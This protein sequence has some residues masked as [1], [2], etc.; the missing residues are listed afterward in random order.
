M[1][2]VYTYATFDTPEH[3]RDAIR[4]LDDEFQTRKIDVL[5]EDPSKPWP[6]REIPMRLTTRMGPGLA[7]G[8]VFGAII[9]TI[10]AVTT[11]LAE[12]GP[13]LSVIGGIVGGAFVG[14]GMGAVAGLGQ[15]RSRPEL[16]QQVSD[17][18]TILVGVAT[19]EDHVDDARRS[20]ARGGAM[21]V[22][23][24][25]SGESLDMIRARQAV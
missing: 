6:T 16:P 25:R 23:V 20:L 9:V 2:A 15:W 17:E 13:V 10:V 24:M 7:I 19:N 4:A 14:G 22:T 3:A 18:S 1:N 21:N 5:L 11:D 8:A 12:V